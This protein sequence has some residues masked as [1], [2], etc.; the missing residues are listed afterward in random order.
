MD[1]Y[2]GDDFVDIVGVDGFNWG[3]SFFWGEGKINKPH[4]VNSFGTGATNQA[5]W[6]ADAVAQ[7]KARGI[8][9]LI[10]FSYP[11]QGGTDFTLT[12]EGKA[13]FHL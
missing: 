13:A 9:G 4:R 6:I 10:Y 5:T 11:G 1:Y 8:S 2:P 3:S 7:A 12:A